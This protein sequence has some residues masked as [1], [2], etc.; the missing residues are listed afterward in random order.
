[1][2]HPGYGF[3]S[4]NAEFARKV[5]AAGITFIGP[6]PEVIESLGDKT[7]ARTIAMNCNV[8]VVP[9]TPGPVSEFTEAKA[10]IKEHGFPIIIK[11][12][13]GGGGRG[14]RVVR[15]EASLEDAFHRAKSE[16]LAAFGDGTVFIERFLDKPRHIEVQLLA[17]RAGNVVHLF[18]RDCSVQRRHQKVVEIAPAKNLDNKVREAILNDA[19]KIAKAVKYKNAGT[20]E[21]LVDNQN[22]HY[23]IEINPRIQVEHTITE[24]ITGIDVVAAQIQIAAG[25]LLPQL[26]LTQQRIR[27]RGFA[28]QCRV[29]TEDPELNFQPDT[30]KI[31]V[32]RSSGGNGVRL[33]G[34]AGYAGAVITPHYDSLLVKVTCSGSTY[35]VARR[36][37]VRALVEF[38]IR[39]VKTNIPFL[40]RLLTCDTFING[41]CWTTFIDDTPDLFRLVQFQNRAQRMLGYLGDV[42]VNGSQIKG[43]VGEPSFKSEIDI[44][45]LRENGSNKDIDVSAPAT[46]G[47][48]KIIVEQG[49]EAFAKA[50][51]AYPGVLITDTTWRDAHQSLLAT[52]VRTVDLLRIAPAT[53]HALANAFS[54]ECWGGATFDVAMR[55]LHEDPWDRL[56]ALR[57]LVPN[58]PFQMLLRGANA[59]GYTS[60]PD[61]VVYEFCDKAVK[62]GMDV[63]RIF[64]SLNYV[65]NMKLGIDAV[66]KAGGVVEATICYTGDVS[67]PERKKYNLDYYVDLTQ[68]LVNEGIHILG[69]KDMAGLLKPEAARLLVSTIRNKFPDLPIHVHTHDTAGTGVASM[70][71]AAAAGADIIDVAIDSMSGMTS[72]P[73]MGAI[74]AGFEQ[75]NLGTGIRMADVHAINSYWEQAR[76]LY[77]CFEANVRAADSGVYDHEMPGG[78]YTNLMFQA[79]QLGLGTQWNQIKKAY[80]EANEL[81]GDLV[82]V[83]P[84]SKV[85]GDLAQFMVS[86]SLSGKDVEE[87]ASSLSFPTSVVEFFQGYLGQP[88][89][90]FP[91]PLRSNI[92][93]EQTRIDGRPGATLPPLDMAK[94]KQELVEKYGSNI[95]DYD[96]ISAALYPKVFAEYREMVN[97]YGD[98]S[99]LPTRYFLSKPEI[100]EEFHVE[101]EEGK[102]LIIKLLAVGP[103]NNNGKRDVYFELNGEA[104]V[105]GI[106]DKNS[107]LEV[108]TRERANLSNPGDIAAPMSGV[109]VE[110]RAKEGA[111]VKAGDPLA[112]LSAMKMET[113]VT[114]PVAGKVERVAVQEGDSLN[115]GDLV[116]RIVKDDA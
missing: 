43:Q 2:I 71:A 45:V 60:Y 112:V 81:C 50:V 100:N 28:I 74:V 46:E 85:V 31:E 103:L 34:G 97:Q 24:E 1:M 99:V 92:I 102:T 82:K 114:S 12:A 37:I 80:Q 83:T 95:R 10:F 26:G 27:Q 30:G 89:G 6:S 58:I 78:Q 47:W 16:A 11:A 39:G 116:A 104:R 86:N 110:I 35:E 55:F 59:V 115:S 33:D 21:F 32:Y 14:M 67:N 23:F 61:N 13:M 106:V 22:R 8:P 109:V 91:E 65:E 64:D 69:I 42:V 70:M 75:T 108:V 48:R 105:V 49:P 84:S 76:L 66:K 88:H 29:T 111:H 79:Q 25:A 41:N 38:R 20:A 17:D 4:E 72:Q 9:G 18:E 36:K 5:E 3:L 54:L 96:V 94:L 98:L 57:K 40:Q 44:P 52:R 68:Q 101:I 63:F 77:S 73:A 87:R 62:C 107:A 53:S 7:K 113:V 90:G 93:R 15:D 51:R 19:I 56:A